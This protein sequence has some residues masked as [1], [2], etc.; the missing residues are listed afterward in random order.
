MSLNLEDL[1]I[2]N[3]NIDIISKKD[4]LKCKTGNCCKLQTQGYDD[5]QKLINRLHKN[6]NDC[7]YEVKKIYKCDDCKNIIKFIYN[8]HIMMA[9]E[10]FIDD[11]NDWPR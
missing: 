7:N 5:A 10:G 1:C 9:E 8:P 4:V 2:D 3:E 6:G 11:Y